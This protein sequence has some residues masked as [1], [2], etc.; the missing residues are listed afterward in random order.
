MYKIK[1][2][3][4]G[5]EYATLVSL[6]NTLELLSVLNNRDEHVLCSIRQKIK[7]KEI[8]DHDKKSK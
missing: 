6:M 5:E 7:V 3:L 8:K 4:T 2:K 1:A